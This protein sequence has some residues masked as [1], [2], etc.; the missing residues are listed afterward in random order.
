VSATAALA[1][2]GPPQGPGGH[3]GPPPE[4]VEACQSLS[5]GDACTVTLH[6]QSLS[7]KCDGPEGKPLACRPNDPPPPP[8]EAIDACQE[9]QDSAA[10]SFTIDG[11]AVKG[12]CHAPQGKQLACVPSDF[13]PPPKE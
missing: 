11:H 5:K 7:G 4:A 6:S 9:L 3:R 13:P 1:D 2:G 12:A 8:Q 10:C